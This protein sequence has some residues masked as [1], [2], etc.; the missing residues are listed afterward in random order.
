MITTDELSMAVELNRISRIVN[1]IVG[2][3]FIISG[4][5]KLFDPSGAQNFATFLSGSKLFASAA[6]ILIVS[7]VE[8]FIGVLFVYNKLPDVMRA[9]LF[10]ILL[11]IMI[12]SISILSFL[13]T[14]IN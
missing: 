9:I 6:T 14:K 7:V 5:G 12:L 11:V 8:I 1:I 10:I 3:V 13:L 4:A 2:V